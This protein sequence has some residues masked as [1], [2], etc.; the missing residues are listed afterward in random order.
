MLRGNEYYVKRKSKLQKRI[1]NNKSVNS[2]NNQWFEM[3]VAACTR[4]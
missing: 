2:Y 4:S 1:L 3:E